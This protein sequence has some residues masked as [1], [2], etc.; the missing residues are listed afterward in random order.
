MRNSAEL[1]ICPADNLRL[2]IFANSVLLNTAEHE[3]FSA[4]KYLLA[5]K[6]SCSAELRMKKVL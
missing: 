6:V 5:E 3:N 2:L 4:N 1:E